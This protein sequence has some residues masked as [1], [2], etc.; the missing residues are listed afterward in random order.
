[1][2]VAIGN[3]LKGLLEPF[4]IGGSGSNK[5][6]DKLAGLVQPISMSEQ[7]ESGA[8]L[9]KI[10]PISCSTTFEECCNNKAYKDLIPNSKYGCMVYFEEES[11]VE[12]VEETRN[13]RKYKTS[14]LLV[15]WVNQKKLGTDECSITGK[16]VNTFINA[17]SVKPFNNDIYTSIQ[18]EVSGQNPK[19]V[20]PFSKYTYDADNTQYLMAPYDYFSVKIDV[21]FVVNSQCIVDFSKGTEQTCNN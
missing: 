21:N 4:E 11:G 13:G 17:L 19:S 18:I 20:N 15:G 7:N 14:F 9:T 16:I 1:M 5:F 10:F 3:I 2:N 8:S 6:I 12:L